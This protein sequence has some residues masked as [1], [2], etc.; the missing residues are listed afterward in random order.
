MTK[1]TGQNLTNYSALVRML[2]EQLS[3]L[4]PLLREQVEQE[5]NELLHLLEDVRPPRFMVIGRRG[6]GKSTLINALF[7]APVA[8]VG[9]VEAQTGEAHWYEYE[10]NGKKIEILDT[11]GIQ[12]GGKPVEADSAKDSQASILRA[13]RQ[14]CPDVVLFLCKAKEVDSAI[15]ESLDIFERILQ[16]IESIHNY[17]PPIVGIL[18]QCDELDPPDI[19]KLPTD[20][21]EK[22]QNISTAVRVL[23]EHL[24]S[25]KT[26]NDKLIEVVPTVAFVRYDA[27]GR[28]DTKRDFRWNIDRLTELLVEEL[29]KGPNLAFARIASVRKFQHKVANNIINVCSIACGAVGASP[30]PCDDLPV[31]TAI[32]AAMIIAIA[33]IGG[34]ELSFQ[35]V[36][37]F[38][39][40][41]GVNVGAAFALREVARGLVKLIPGFGI[42]ISA[43]V[44]STGTQAI[45]QAA[46][47]YF[48]DGTPV[49]S[50]LETEEYTTLKPMLSPLSSYSQ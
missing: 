29:P 28:F 25:R 5:L 31:I 38:L 26:L 43:G 36:P 1:T 3:H 35:T 42:V 37:E 14:S 11:R 47:A 30:I 17:N 10:H 13:V 39:T 41:L 9:A 20:D 48:I 27:D 7:N 50:I 12:E 21:E 33:Y 40:A 4:P 16:E 2:L 22:N 24:N 32:Q 23:A 46:I 18:T 34:R 49:K 45:G 15:N 6:A 44:A 8:K 19:R